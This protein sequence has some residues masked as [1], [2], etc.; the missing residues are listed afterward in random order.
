MAG[1]L[2]TRASVGGGQSTASASVPCA[3]CYAA[4]RR[5]SRR[6]K[7]I[8][9]HPAFDA[10]VLCVVAANTICLAIDNPTLD[11]QG[12]VKARLRALDIAFVIVFLLEMLTKMAALG[13]WKWKNDA[14][15]DPARRKSDVGELLS[16]SQQE[17]RQSEVKLGYFNDPWNRLDFIIVLE[18]ILTTILDLTTDQENP[19]FSAIRTLR[20]LR[21]LRTVNHLPGLKMMVVS[22]TESLPQ[23][24]NTSIGFIVY[25]IAF[26]VMGIQLFR[27]ALR[28]RCVYANGTLGLG[29]TPCGGAHECLPDQYCDAD[30]ASNPDY[31]YTSFDNFG[32]TFLILW[33]CITME[34]W[35]HVMYLTQQAVSYWAFLYFIP[36]ILF[37]AYILLN[38][39]LA[40]I[41]SKFR[42]TAQEYSLISC[43][44]Q[45]E[46]RAK[47]VARIVYRD[48]YAAFNKWKKLANA[49]HVRSTWL[50]TAGTIK[51]I[52]KIMKGVSSKKVG[53][54]AEETYTQKLCG[55]ISVRWQ[56]F[57]D[58]VGVF[59]AH[60]LFE[61]TMSLLIVANAVTMSMEQY[62][63]SDEREIALSQSN[64][65]FTFAFT[66][67]MVIKLVGLRFSGYIADSMNIFDAFIVVISL[68]DYALDQYI[69]V[70]LSSGSVFRVMRIFRLLRILRLA[71]LARYM[72]AFQH[73]VA[74]V[75]RSLNSVGYISLL[76]LLFMLVFC[77][78]GMQLFGG[79]FN[80]AGDKPRANFE[81]V[82]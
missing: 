74:V 38:L 61:R 45:F 30:Q 50:T 20:V 22:F 5:F 65:F 68:V 11:Q 26:D 23:L 34:G 39:V 82:H 9:L 3:A 66:A 53:I 58:Q 71:K 44:A 35:S 41:V 59:C 56:N 76:L 13:L 81:Y 8:L 7:K 10:T 54:V 70:D 43:Q 17:R 73:L 28:Q 52:Q 33:L 6:C 48:R 14:K 27:G 69:K 47:F 4:R 55:N 79:Q 24:G 42:D 32:S 57:R 49:E 25:F 37:G 31:G 2:V 62:G 77:V 36:M 67:E 78:L 40:V 64:T 1:E 75:T 18:S 46:R 29:D 15:H 12:Q 21:P 51:N 63:M 19:T 16:I 72:D 60:S 80:F